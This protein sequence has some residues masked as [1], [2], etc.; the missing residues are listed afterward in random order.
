MIAKVGIVEEITGDD[1][2][3]VF[4]LYIS[5]KLIQNEKRKRTIHFVA[6]FALYGLEQIYI[7]IVRIYHYSNYSILDELMR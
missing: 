7:G 3:T 6:C 1:D 4:N 5:D 2:L